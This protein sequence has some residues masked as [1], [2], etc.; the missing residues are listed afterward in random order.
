MTFTDEDGNKHSIVDRRVKPG[1]SP[2]YYRGV[3]SICLG[4]FICPSAGTTEVVL[5]EQSVRAIR[6]FLN[7]LTL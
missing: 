7:H 3:G 5:T 2:D 1:E 6:D 4:I